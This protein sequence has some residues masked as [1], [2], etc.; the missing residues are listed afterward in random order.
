MDL[1]T[2]DHLLTTTRSVRKRLDLKRAVDLATV[3]RCLEIALQ[4]PTGSNSQG[5]HFLIVTDPAKRAGLA[6]LY[7]RAFEGYRELSANS[8]QLQVGD[9]RRE[10]TLRIV[11]SASYLAERLHEVPVMIVPCIEGRVENAGVLAQA[12]IY[13]S[14]LPAVWSLMLALRSRGLG[15]AWTTLHLMYE[16][17]AAEILGVPEHITQAALLPIA[18]FT[19]TDFKPAKRLPVREHVH[20]NRWGGKGQ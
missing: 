2:T 20:W 17:E 9:P 5:W 18:Y 11:D 12:S 13:G 10:Q 8:P 16:A 6:D 3:E 14:I 7:R 1:K 15:S 19:G 4:A